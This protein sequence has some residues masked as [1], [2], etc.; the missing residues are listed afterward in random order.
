MD[1]TYVRKVQ[2]WV[3]LDNRI[4]KNKEQIKDVVEKKTALETEILEYA[5][6]KKID[7]L[8]L[9]ISDGNIKFSKK[10]TTQ[11]LSNRLLKTLLEKYTEEK[12]VTLNVND[13]C[14]YVTNS[15][16]K[17]SSIYMKRNIRGES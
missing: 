11:Q 13:V 10:N 16:E 14:N 8:T 12:G 4:M 1:I 2:E 15:L 5:E 7:D 3:E 17:K 6:D 9:S